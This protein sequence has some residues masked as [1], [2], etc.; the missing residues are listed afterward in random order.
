MKYRIAVLTLVAVLAVTPAFAQL[1]SGIVFDPTNYK[2]A[3]LR[4]I[5]LQQQLQQLQQ[6]YNLYLQQ[7]QFMQNQA[8]Q[9]QDMNARYRAQFSQWRQLASANT[10]GNTGQWVNGVNSGNPT[11]ISSGYSRIVPPLPN[12]PLT[13]FSPE[14]QSTL[15]TQHGTLELEDAAN[16]QSLRTIG[17]IRGNAQ[18]IESMLSRLEN[19]SLS[20]DDRQNTQV[21]V[22]NKINAGNVVLARSIQ[23][24]NKLLLQ[25]LEQTT[26]KTTQER[27]QQGQQLNDALRI[28]QLIEQSF[29]E[30]HQ[31]PASGPFRL[32]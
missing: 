5:Q 12:Y 22:L 10:Y 19:D 24:T 14:L 11:T 13:E 6:T 2:N 26:Q 31:Q 17:E 7:Y 25:L 21:A 32:P 30:A 1:G 18:Q 23:D 3:V 29:A 8:R 15:Q 20:P 27:S 9:I 28:R 4:Y 16:I